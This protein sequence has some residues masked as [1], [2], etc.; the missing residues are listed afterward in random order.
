MGFLFLIGQ[1]KQ[2]CPLLK[3]YVESKMCMKTFDIY[4]SENTG[5]IESQIHITATACILSYYE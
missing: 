3:T 5:L 1:I 2:K 4:I